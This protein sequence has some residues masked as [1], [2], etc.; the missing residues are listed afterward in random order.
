M[1]SLHWIAVAS[2][3]GICSV[4]LLNFNDQLPGSFRELCSFRYS[5]PY[6]VPYVQRSN[7]IFA[8]VTAI[9]GSMMTAIMSSGLGVL[10]ML[11]CFALVDAA[12]PPF[13][14]TGVLG[15]KGSLDCAM[16]SLAFNFFP[17]LRDK[18]LYDALQLQ[19]CGVTLP[20]ESFADSSQDKFK[21]VK[22]RIQEE[23]I[24][25]RCENVV[26]V[27][28]G[29]PIHEALER[30]RGY[31]Y[32]QG[33]CAR[34]ELEPGIHF[35]NRT[36]VLDRR[37]NGLTIVGGGS[38]TTWLS[39]GV[40][41]AASP[42]DPPPLDLPNGLRLH[43][44][45]IP[46]S[47]NGVPGLFGV[48]PHRRFQRARWPNGDTERDQWGYASPLS[49]KVS[50]P[51]KTVEEWIKREPKPV[52]TFHYVDLRR[53]NPTGFVKD[54]STQEEY[55]M[56]TSGA[57]G[58]CDSMW[59][60][61]YSSSYWCGNASS[62]GWAE[63]DQKFAKS[64][65]VGLPAG[66]RYAA[67]GIAE[68]AKSWK[69]LEEGPAVIHAWHSQ[70]WFTNMFEVSSHS[71]AERTIRFGRGGSQGGRSWCQ[72]D[73]CTYVAKAWCRNGNTANAVDDRLISGNWYIEN[74]REELDAPGEFYFDPVSRRVLLLL[75]ASDDVQTFSVP[76]LETL[77]RVQEGAERVRIE[78]IGFRD[79]KLTYLHKHG[80][81]SGGDWS[82]YKGAA[83]MLG[84]VEDVVVK[85][86]T[87]AR[88][89]GTAVLVH[90]RARG[91]RIEESEFEWLGESAIALW[92]RTKEWDGRNGTQ[93]RGT[94]IRRNVVREIG[95]Y[96]KQSSAV[97]LAKT[98]NAT[99][100]ENLFYN[101]PRAAI[102]LN[103]GFGGGNVIEKN[104]IFNT[105]RE[106]GDH[107]A[108]NSWDRQ[109]FLYDTSSGFSPKMTRI[110]QNF[111][112]AN[113]GASQG[114]GTFELLANQ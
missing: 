34:L 99:I 10:L 60:T 63:V 70:S 1:C 98:C 33:R 58:V 113:Y 20:F 37:D 12:L 78:G 45:E 95:I 14:A 90:D 87:F 102:N 76:I 53:E 96:Q 59:D 7:H 43:S 103:D 49:R 19:H 104:L 112:F 105:C 36:I 42:S 32:A 35:L 15:G 84:N 61:S 52:P 75:N 40:R 8:F 114:V 89:D 97:F 68:R 80:V 81:P 41:V 62:G 86:C 44:F 57:G 93:P 28:P 79:A 17:N 27:S 24:H 9:N 74:V 92:G 88:L 85:A 46:E 22:K 18:Q 26:R 69:K 55:N 51:L 47:L 77:I 94:V 3:F 23:Q 100:E 4:V 56:Y 25:D 91:V 39:G 6:R 65:T 31:T 30:T 48:C 71:I 50:N 29:Y 101:M 21:P 2:K 67:G 54:D 5:V 64:G 111:I 109:P 83:V 13:G 38:R 73:Q 72:C 106:S 11:L 110:S 66:M 82:L 16:R 107:G 108:I